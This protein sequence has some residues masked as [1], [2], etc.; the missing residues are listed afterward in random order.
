M[1]TLADGRKL[2]IT[3]EMFISN[4]VI[5]DLDDNGIISSSEKRALKKIKLN[6]NGE[7]LPAAQATIGKGSGVSQ[8]K[9][10]TLQ[11]RLVKEMTGFTKELAN[12]PQI[13]S[14]ID[15]SKQKS[16]SESGYKL[17]SIVPADGAVSGFD[18]SISLPK[19]ETTPLKIEDLV[20]NTKVPGVSTETAKIIA[21]VRGGARMGST[22]SKLSRSYYR[23]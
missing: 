20:A 14:L 17:L 3:G 10:K 5:D 4:A 13:Q 23:P 12:P 7:L 21:M 9:L 19:L 8:K 16:K 22:P 15:L 2:S 1:A 11:D 6:Q 18:T